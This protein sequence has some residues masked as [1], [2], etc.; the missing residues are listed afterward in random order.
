[1]LFRSTGYDNLRGHLDGGLTAWRALG[2][3]V[4]RVRTISPAALRDRMTAGEA[5]LVLDVRSDGEWEEAHIPG[6]VHIQN[7]RLPFDDLPLPRD[8]PIV[9]HCQLRNRSM[10]GLSVLARRGYRNL[11]LLDGGFGAWEAAR[12]EVERGPGGGS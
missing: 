10:A 12:F 2:L 4:E 8:R 3:P 9:V 6:A 11:A 1:M 7:G 5:P